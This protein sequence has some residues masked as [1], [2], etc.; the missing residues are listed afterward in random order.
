VRS[1]EKNIIEEGEEKG[2]EEE[3]GCYNCGFER[4]HREVS[5]LPSM[6]STQE[7]TVFWNMRALW[8]HHDHSIF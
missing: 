3:D 5:S 7:K 1:T 4:R 8:L 2:E 6:I